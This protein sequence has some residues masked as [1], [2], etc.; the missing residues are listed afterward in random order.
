LKEKIPAY[1]KENNS[2]DSMSS[3]ASAIPAGA[4]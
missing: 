4:R 2:T 1:L 3:N